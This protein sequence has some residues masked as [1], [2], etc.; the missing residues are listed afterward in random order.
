MEDIYQ[1]DFPGLI[2]GATATIFNR[3]KHSLQVG[4]EY[5]LAFKPAGAISNVGFTIG[6]QFL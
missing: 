4:V 2:L 5:A 3:G 1:A 6:Y